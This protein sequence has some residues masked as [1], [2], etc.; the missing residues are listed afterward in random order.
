MEKTKDQRYAQ[1]T[2]HTLFTTI[3]VELQSKLQREIPMMSTIE[4]SEANVRSY[5]ERNEW[6]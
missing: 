1:N 4:D 5:T 2:V 3:H 6:W